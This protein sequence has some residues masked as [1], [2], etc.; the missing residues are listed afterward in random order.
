[1]QM[2][3]LAALA[4]A[5]GLAGAAGAQAGTTAEESTPV[6]L[7]VE[8]SIA[9][10]LARI[11]RAMASEHYSELGPEDKGKVRAAIDRIRIKAGDQQ[12][13]AQLAPQVRTEVVNDQEIIN[14]LLS[15]AHADS[16]MVCRR[17]RTT[18]SNRMQR[19]CMTV[20]QQREATERGR[21]ALENAQR[22]GPKRGGF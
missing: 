16:R 6:Q 12:T 15:Q 21:N 7:N 10:Q 18:G 11:E 19:V 20:A 14:T 9:D 4:V 8:T 13:V 1:M 2:F 22:G 17:E 5:L 3:R